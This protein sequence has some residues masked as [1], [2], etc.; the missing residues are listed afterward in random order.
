VTFDPACGP[1][2]KKAGQKS[3]SQGK[4]A[5]GNSSG[6]DITRNNG[7]L[8]QLCDDIKPLLL[9]QNNAAKVIKT[10]L[11]LSLPRIEDGNN[12]GVEVMEAIIER[13]N[14]VEALSEYRMESI[15]DFYAI[16]AERISKLT[17]DK[18]TANETVLTAI[19]EM[20]ESQFTKLKSAVF[21]I[22]DNYAGILDILI[23]NRDKLQTPRSDHSQNMY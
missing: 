1:T 10:W 12:F 8:K 22:R 17:A 6:A 20:D 15:A 21:D 14:F 4:T 11:S 3:S 13:V 18:T 5:S 19:S 23:K 9:E 2:K 7:Q 16:R